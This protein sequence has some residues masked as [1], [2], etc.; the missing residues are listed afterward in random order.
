MQE[1][2]NAE[3]NNSYSVGP[4]SSCNQSCA[5][6]AL[7]SIWNSFLKVKVKSQH[8]NGQSAILIYMSDVTNKV[9]AKLQKM[10]IREKW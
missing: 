5:D 6:S 2:R 4:M 1:M 10:Q 8:Y 7:P 9:R 3:N